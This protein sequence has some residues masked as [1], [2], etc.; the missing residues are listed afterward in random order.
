MV[1]SVGTAGAAGL[2]G[3]ATGWV[4]SAQQVVWAMV[5]VALP[6]AVGT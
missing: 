2:D 5:M 1:G 3:D 6:P 4:A